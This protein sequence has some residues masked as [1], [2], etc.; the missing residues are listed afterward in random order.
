MATEIA[1]TSLTANRRGLP[2]GAHERLAL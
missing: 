1:V 2:T